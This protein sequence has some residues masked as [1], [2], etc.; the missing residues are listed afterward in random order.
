MHDN[1]TGERVSGPPACYLY[2]GDYAIW[3]QPFMPDWDNARRAVGGWGG[4]HS[5]AQGQLLSLHHPLHYAKAWV[6]IPAGGS[7]GRQLAY[8]LTWHTLAHRTAYLNRIIKAPERPR[9][10]QAARRAGLRADRKELI[11]RALMIP[12]PSPIGSV[13]RAPVIEKYR[14]G[15]MRVR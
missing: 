4:H 6:S 7:W 8:K 12:T 13:L 2:L 14:R 5:R 9:R 10:G 1:G 3:L 15:R 11:N